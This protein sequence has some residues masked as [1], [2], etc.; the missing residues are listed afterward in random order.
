MNGS[1]IKVVSR[2]S[3]VT[4]PVLYRDNTNLFE[5]FEG[6]F[7]WAGTDNL[8]TDGSHAGDVPPCI[9]LKDTSNVHLQHR[10]YLRQ[11]AILS[12]S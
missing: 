2:N 12:N 11:L 6:G 10:L 4:A 5:G 7:G 3:T 8:V 1:E 9:S